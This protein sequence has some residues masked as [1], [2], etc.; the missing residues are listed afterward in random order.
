[1]IVSYKIRIDGGAPL[2]VGIP[3]PLEYLKTGLSPS[4]AYDVEVGASDGWNPVVWSDVFTYTTPANSLIWTSHIAADWD[5][6]GSYTLTANADTFSSYAP[7]V[8]P[9]FNAI[10]DYLQFNFP[11]MSGNVSIFLADGSGHL[12]NLLPTGQVN[13]EGGFLEFDTAY[14]D[15]DD[16]KVRK[17]TATRF[18]WSINGGAFAEINKD[19]TGE[20]TAHLGALTQV[21]V[22]ILAPTTNIVF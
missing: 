7:Y 21:G 13:D 3:T 15:G 17:K 19:M 1:M 2:D 14:T 12:I 10:G 5:I 16:I 20:V 22:V 9:K 8:V 11:G 18:E 6:D 4:T